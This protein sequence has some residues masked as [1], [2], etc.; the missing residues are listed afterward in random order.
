MEERKDA[1][2]DFA[3]TLSSLD[4]FKG[5]EIGTE[6][7]IDIWL[8]HY[9]VRRYK[10]FDFDPKMRDKIVTLFEESSK[11]QME[12][13]EYVYIMGLLNM[14]IHC[15]KPLTVDTFFWIFLMG[16]EWAYMKS[17]E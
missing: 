16:M 9:I 12:F 7:I 5:K 1:F 14:I 15:T 8:A 3:E 4:G 11:A 2:K 10:Q 13:P 6:E 17:E